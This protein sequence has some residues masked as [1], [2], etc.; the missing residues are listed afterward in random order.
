M[1]Y[2]HFVLIG[3]FVMLIACQKQSEINVLVFTK[4]EYL[5]RVKA[6]WTAQ[7]VAVHMGW[8]FE[9][10]PAAV[11]PVNGYS[12]SRLETIRKNG[13]AQIDDDWYYEMVALNG[14]EKYGSVMTVEE[15]GQQ[16][17]NYNMGTWGSAFYTR[18]AL[19]KG[20]KGAEA[21]K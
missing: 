12:E 15:L 6:M 4:A 19:L 11:V 9:H 2:Y 21:N 13:G 1:K 10:K 8:D 5:D 17:L 3:I 18:L 20:L 16:W 14:F 7:L